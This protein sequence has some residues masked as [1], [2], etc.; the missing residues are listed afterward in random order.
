MLLAIVLLLACACAVPLLA[1]LACFVPVPRTVVV[2]P[3]ARVSVVRSE[4]GRPIAG[5]T[6]VLARWS[7]PHDQPQGRWTAATD[8]HGE[9]RFSRREQSERVLPLMMHGVPFYRWNLCAEAPG[10]APRLVMPW[11]VPESGVVTRVERL[12]LPAGEGTCGDASGRGP[13]L[14]PTPPRAR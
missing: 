4:D 14:S 3:R 9:A 5:A 7:D 8:A 1:P 6:V 11:D 10:R 13:A 2:T 12:E